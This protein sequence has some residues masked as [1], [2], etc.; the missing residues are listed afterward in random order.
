MQI[1]RRSRKKIGQRSTTEISLKIFE[2]I[3]KA[4]T[5]VAKLIATGS[6]NTTERVICI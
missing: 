3:D 1:G 4:T 2:T 5:V 6:R